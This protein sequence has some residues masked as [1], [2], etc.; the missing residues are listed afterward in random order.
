MMKRLLCAALLP[1][2]AV[3][4]QAIDLSVT[5][6]GAVGDGKTDCTASIQKAL[7]E[8]SQSG[9]GRVRVPAGMFLVL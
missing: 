4:A 5:A 7:D 1:A 9:G 2:L 6:F 8:A 3:S